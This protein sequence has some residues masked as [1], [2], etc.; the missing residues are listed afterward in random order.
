[1]SHVAAL[2]DNNPGYRLYVTGHSLGVALATAFAFTAAASSDPRIIKPVTCFSVASPKV[3][4]LAFRLA[5]EVNLWLYN[6]NWKG[7][8]NFAYSAFQTVETRLLFV[9]RFATT[10]ACDHTSKQTFV[11]SV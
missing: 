8:G 5:T 10:G 4:N 3:G 11:M 2:L 6:S 9:P 7:K 1:M